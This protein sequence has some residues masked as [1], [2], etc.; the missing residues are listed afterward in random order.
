MNLIAKDSL[1]QGVQ[2]LNKMRRT[3]KEWLGRRITSLRIRLKQIVKESLDRILR[4]LNK[5]Q[6]T[7]KEWLG[8]RVTSLRIRF[9]LRMPYYLFCA[10][11]LA[12]LG[13]FFV[14]LTRLTTKLAD[15]LPE[16][17]LLALA[18][19]VASAFVACVLG[20]RWF[21]SAI[22]TVKEIKQESAPGR[23]GYEP[24]TIRLIYDGKKVRIDGVV[25]PQQYRLYFS[26]RSNYQV[27][28][29]VNDGMF[30]AGEAAFFKDPVP[31]LVFPPGK[32]PK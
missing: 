29:S 31:N 14:G 6:Q 11:T 10:A 21:P 2:S 32:V 24:V 28:V 5:M 30:E 1:N 3:A 26:R 15:N 13:L 8:R 23:V 25:L 19:G 16:L 17:W 20:R 9:Q 27:Y 22:L 7:A 18:I 12:S 4:S